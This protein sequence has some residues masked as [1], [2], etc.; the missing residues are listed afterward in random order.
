MYTTTRKCRICGGTELTSAFDLGVQYLT[1]VFPKAVDEPVTA[2]PV[3]L[4]KCTAPDG[5]GLVQLRQSYNSEEMYG[6]NYGYRSGLNPSMVRHLTSKVEA[7]LHYGVLQ[8]GDVVVDI[9]SNDGTTLRAYPQGKYELV[10]IDPTGVKFADYYP[11]SIRLMPEFFSAD[12]LGRALGGRKAKVITSFSMFYDLEDPTAFARE[13]HDAL[14]D[15]GIWV[16]EQSYLPAMLATNSFDTICHEHLEFYTLKQIKWMADRVGLRLVDVEFNGV[17]GG[18]LFVH[19]GQIHVRAPQPPA[20]AGQGAGARTVLWPGRHGRVQGVPG[21]RAGRP[22]GA[23]GLSDAGRGRR[24]NRVRDRR[25]HQRQRAAAVLWRGA[26]A[27]AAHRRG[28]PRQIRRLH[29]RH[30]HPPGGGGR[31]AGRQPRLPFGAAVALS[32][33]LFEQPEV[34]G[35]YARVPAAAT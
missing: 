16:C 7:I 10:G 11:A 20:G 29:S 25:V 1:G 3:E 31:V 4:V 8:D 27:A 32:G 35:A 23:A 18:E 34:Q 17:N 14:D 19:G 33:V 28:Q 9:G 22:P 15:E 13:I 26:E 21:A 12:A 5:C 30:A 2:G 6:A 24:Q